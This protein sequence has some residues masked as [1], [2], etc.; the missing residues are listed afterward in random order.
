MA[1]RTKRVAKISLHRSAKEPLRRA[2]LR[3]KEPTR[4]LASL[5]AIAAAVRGSLD[6]N[7]VL[8]QALD[9]ILDV[10]DMEAGF[11]CFPEG[12]PPQLT[13]KVHK[14]ISPAFVK[15]LQREVRWG[16]KSERVFATRKSLIFD[17]STQYTGALR[18]RTT[19]REGFSAAAWV[20]ITLKE[21][22][23]GIISVRT[24]KAH[25][26]PRDR[27]PLLESIGASVGVA[28]ENAQLF[29]EVKNKTGELK[30][31]NR[32]LR[33]ANL[34]LNRLLQEQ[35]SLRDILTQINVL[36][37]GHLL[38]QLAR[39]A[40]TL[41]HVDHIQIRLL[42]KD[43]ILRT[44]AF[45]GE[46][47]ELQQGRLLEFGKGRSSW[48]MKNSKPL[49][50]KDIRQ[51]KVFGPGHLLKELGVKGYLLVPMISRERKSIGVLGAS[52]LTEREF[53][54][55]E[56]S[57]AQQF[58]AGAAIAIENANLYR[59]SQRREEIQRLFKELS[60][61]ITSL[62]LDSLL[63]KLTEKVRK[64][65]KVDVADV[66]I[67]E[68]NLWHVR[69]LSGIDPNTVP[70][71]QTG[72][73]RGR[74]H[75]ILKNRQ[76]LMLPDIVQSEGIASGDTL[77]A[78]GI[79][80]YLG[81]PIFSR[82]GEVIGVLRALM[83]EPRE[84]SQEEV[85]LL[86]QLANGAAVALENAQL[87]QETERRAQEQEA[88]NAIAAAT[89]Q[90]LR[91]DELL[92][93]A[94][95]KVLEITGRERA[96]IRLKDP[97]TGEITLAAHRGISEEYAETLL[98]KR[99]PGGKSDQVFESGE[100]LIIN[101]PEGI[102][103][104]EETRREGNRS[105]AWLPL[106]ARGKVVGILS[107]STSQPRS[108]EPR[109]VELLVAIGNVIGAALE[110]AR[111]FEE[112]KRRSQELQG[113]Y[114]ITSATTQSLDLRST[115][116]SALLKTI[117]VLRVDAGRLYVF[118]KSRHELRLTAHHGLPDGELKDYVSYVPGEGVVG[119][120]FKECRPIAF[121]DITSDPRY[122]AM[123]RRTMGAKWG[124]RSAV[125]LPITIKGQPIGVIYLY[126]RAVREFT[127]QDLQL[128]QAIG[129]QIGVAIENSRL[130]EE[131][132]RQK[133]VQKL[134]KELGQD[135]TSLNIDSLLKKLT[136]KVRK[137]LKVDV[138]DV[139]VR[140]GEKWQVKG[141]SGIDPSGFRRFKT[142]TARGRSGWILKNRRALSISDITQDEETPSGETLKRVG[143]RGYLGVPLFSRSGQVVGVLRALTYPPRKF[144]QDEVDLLQ[145]LSNGVAIVLENSWLFRETERRAQEQE[146]L[147]A[148]ARATSQS[149]RLD[150]LLHISLDKVLEVT[151][152][153][154]AYIRLKDP[155]TGEI[156][157][158]A[159]RGISEE[160]AE[161][162]VHNRTPGGKSDQVFESGEPLI[163]N[164]IEGTILKRETR[165]EGNSSIGWFPLKGRGEVVGILTVSTSESRPFEP[166][167]VELL[168]AIGNVIGVALEN[169]RLFE[170]SNRLV[171]ELKE[172]T[173]LLGAKN[174]EL[175][176]F[177]YTVSHDLKAPLVT[178]QG[179]AD[180]LL[181]EYEGKLDEQGRHYLDRL[182]AN[183]QQMEQL[184]LD[185][186]A[187][188]RVGKEGHRP[189]EVS[190]DQVVDDLLLEWGETIRARGIRVVRHDLPTLWGVQTHIEQVMTNLLS[191]AV[192]YLGDSAA[193]LIEIGAKDDGDQRVECTVR[194][195][196]IGIDPAYHE[197]IFE[198][199]QRLKET[200]AEGS[201]VG[202]AIVK[203]II[204]G[205]GGRTWVESA[206]GQGS[207]F[208]F[209]WLKA[210]KEVKT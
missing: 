111:L 165:Q 48:V 182:K 49:A 9:T 174:K 137:L 193:P 172:L 194:D 37:L 115:V 142:E 206:K 2:R 85:D 163:V 55:E 70:A 61:D 164:D 42:G 139:R 150:E 198:I 77:K 38:P 160:Y 47:A 110:N 188:S 202:L 89:S 200:K 99:T 177:V 20:P 170:D 15:K 95:D 66:R 136:D 32:D 134:L 179:M 90:S 103:L 175:D 33:E 209:T 58:A 152:R 14:G 167:E 69:G 109:E 131:T 78:L 149:L 116:H 208:H 82:G 81:V 145:Q 196:G 207:T 75:W 27:I 60:Q 192:K 24:R 51:D 62:D 76:A 3:E 26:F 203:K 151:G 29:Q 44:V 191:N 169:A 106:K 67:R 91:L 34:S 181:S 173:D 162:L 84:F 133:E 100:P 25:I 54:H 57:L 102:L 148:I 204:E 39:Q 36:D 7:Q 195:N 210:Q 86:Q 94:L 17:T 46:R 183:A 141:L 154:R 118:D 155:E 176:T 4:E 93:A 43:G 105:M 73:P 23:V 178:L 140:E 146:A 144:T 45:A 40:L 16:G 96:Y 123:A 83:Y 128:L 22:V 108:F 87:F 72:E 79:R 31:L 189:E 68:G 19:I 71:T 138:A 205:A 135:I 52:C 199:F 35:S 168:Q 112:T 6:L 28:L 190:L 186:L 197:K 119:E 11:I 59:E 132:E 1:D 10:T 114:T 120:I 201:G 166:R 92:Q 153:E 143:I 171:K 88:L 187:L 126:G 98:H 104:K 161:T 147:N 8:A 53:T 127:P 74:S 180:L 50:I 185:L 156:T 107:V 101:D 117:E 56:I 13:L 12:E 125:G 159:H 5:H 97:E 80:G 63:K 184:V 158:A 30:G 121:S 65:L 130:Y 64:L 41:L 18:P 122:S 157:L 113:L 129:G 124:F 21:K